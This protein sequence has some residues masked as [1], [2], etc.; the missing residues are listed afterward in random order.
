VNISDRIQKIRQRRRVRSNPRRVSRNPVQN[1]RPTSES[2][3]ESPGEEDARQGNF[4]S[5]DVYEQARI[6]AA[7]RA[8]NDFLDYHSSGEHRSNS[9]SAIRKKAYDKLREL[10]PQQYDQLRPLVKNKIDQEL[11]DPWKNNKN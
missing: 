3:A 5:Q 2:I 1:P 7:E 11:L 8:K 6:H 9:V 4:E 10:Y